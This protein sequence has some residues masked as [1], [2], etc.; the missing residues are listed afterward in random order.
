MLSIRVVWTVFLSCSILLA[1]FLHLNII[2]PQKKKSQTRAQKRITENNLKNEEQT[3][4]K[5]EVVKETSCFDL[6]F[7][8]PPGQCFHFV[9]KKEPKWRFLI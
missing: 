7:K 4:N 9:A 2:D 5:V 6:K 1:F 8:N 3:Q